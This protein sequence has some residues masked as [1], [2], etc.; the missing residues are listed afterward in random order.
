MFDPDVHRLDEW[1]VNSVDFSLYLSDYRVSTQVSARRGWLS[2]RLTEH[3]TALW[4]R[5][6]SDA[7]P[8]L[9]TYGVGHKLE[10]K[11]NKT[12]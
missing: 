7:A 3:A 6:R 10:L 12:M 9:L 11:H 8:Q 2:W 1:Q 5:L 4:P